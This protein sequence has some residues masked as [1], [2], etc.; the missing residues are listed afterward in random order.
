MTTSNPKPTEIYAGATY[1]DF[2]AII[3]LTDGVILGEFDRYE[4]DGT[5]IKTTK[6][7]D[8][9]KTLMLCYVYDVSETRHYAY[10]SKLVPTATWGDDW[11]DS[12]YEHNTCEPYSRYYDLIVEFTTEL[13]TPGQRA[14]SNSYYSVQTINKGA[15]AWL[16]TTKNLPELWVSNDN[17]DEE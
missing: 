3:E 9:T 1:G 11:N 5:L 2:K 14:D 16:S 12:P 10:F 17:S 8:E 7:F 4:T 6:L 13:L 15:I